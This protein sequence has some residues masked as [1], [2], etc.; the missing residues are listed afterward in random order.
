ML[1]TG[2]QLPSVA[3]RPSRDIAGARKETFRIEK[4]DL[5]LATS[6][7]GSRLSRRQTSRF[8]LLQPIRLKLP[9]TEAVR[10][11]SGDLIEGVSCRERSFGRES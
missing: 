11:T 2:I 5:E 9:P 1:S 8:D 4:A 7:P 6:F 10:K 3:S